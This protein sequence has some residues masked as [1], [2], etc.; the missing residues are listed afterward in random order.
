ML[1]TSKTNTFAAKDLQQHISSLNRKFHFQT[2]HKAL[3]EIAVLYNWDRPIMHSPVK[4]FGK[5]TALNSVYVFTKLPNDNDELNQFMGKPKIKRTFTH[6]DIFEKIFNQSN[7]TILNVI[8]SDADINI[9]VVDTSTWRK[10]FNLNPEAMM[11]KNHFK[12]CLFQLH[13]NVIPIDAF[14]IETC[15]KR[16]ENPHSTSAVINVYSDSVFQRTKTH[17]TEIKFEDLTFSMNCNQPI[18]NIIV[19]GFFKKTKSL[20][21]MMSNSK[22]LIWPKKNSASI[23]NMSHYM[24]IQDYCAIFKSNDKY[25]IANVIDGTVFSVKILP[26]ESSVIC[27]LLIEGNVKPIN[28]FESF[29]FKEDLVDFSKVECTKENIIR[30]DF[31]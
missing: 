19:C 7:R 12:K 17:S 11:V 29:K 28:E 15:Q 24:Q 25:G 23:K 1:Q 30:Y 21:D 8:R 18:E 16:Y 31:I 27:S 5:K 9:N 20:M 6:K 26:P 4:K 13:G 2:L 10:N 14:R 22:T 3:E